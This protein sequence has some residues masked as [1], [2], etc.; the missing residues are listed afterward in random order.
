MLA[1]PVNLTPGEQGLVLVTF[2]DL[3][4]AVSCARGEDEAIARAVDVLD[5]ILECYRAE[6]RPIPKPSDI[7]GVPL[8]VSER[9]GRN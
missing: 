6:G 3:P 5:I 1:Y 7:D 4:E 2:P 8:V 9:F